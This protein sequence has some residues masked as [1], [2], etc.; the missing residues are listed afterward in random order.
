MSEQFNE[1]IE[2]DF[3]DE[4]QE[5]TKK[6]RKKKPMTTGKKWAT[7]VAMALVFGLIA[8][9]TMFGVNAAGNYLAGNDSASNQVGQT[10]TTSSDSNSSSSDGSGQGTVAEV[11]KNA[12]PSVVTISTMSVEEMRNFFGGTQQYEVQGAGTGVIVGENDTELLIATNN[13]VIEG[14][15]SLSVGFIDEE[16]VEAEVKGTDVNNDLAVVSVKLSDIPADTMNQIKIATVG[17]S[18]QLQLGDQVV[19]IGNALG[20]GQSVT[21]GYVSALNRDLT[22][23][24]QSGTTINSTGLIQTDAAINEGNSGG[25]LLNM[26]GELIGIN[27]AKSSST[28]TGATVDNIGFAIPI[29]KAEE[30]LQQ[31]MNLKTRERVD[32]SQA[33]YLGIRGSDVSYE[34]S[35]MYGIPTGVVISEV[36]ENGPADQAGVKS[37]DV[38]TELDGHS[39]SNMSQLQDVLEYYAAGETVDID[40]Q[41]ADNGEYQAQTLSITLGSA[42]DAQN[43]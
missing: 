35:E 37:G 11:A 12:M 17:D 24:D 43:Q 29:D 19:A 39:I 20:Y 25:A 26:K 42:S 41:R 13:H 14:A 18:D 36:V 7:V 32:A 10:Q 30:S 16:S 33:S 40:V 2:R 22:L 34:A 28:S 31:L 21:S 4:Q 38:L 8:G 15:A 1:N 3:T 5:K 6:V 9:G 27:E 23:T